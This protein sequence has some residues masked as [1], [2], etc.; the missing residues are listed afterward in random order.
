MAIGGI[1]A[2][3]AGM[4]SIL[5]AGTR[6]LTGAGG[7]TGA[8]SASFF[9]SGLAL[10]VAKAGASDDV[11]AGALGANGLAVTSDGDPG[12]TRTFGS[13]QAAANEAT[14]SRLFAGQHTIID[15]VAGQ[16]LGRHVAQFVL[17]DLGSA[18]RDAH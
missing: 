16:Q 12:V 5:A 13:F 18:P 14:L 17:T 8:A 7:V 4:A 10:T 3:L 2:R 1:F 6:L 15:L 9:A 11:V